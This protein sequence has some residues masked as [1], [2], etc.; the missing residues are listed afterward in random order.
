LLK[1]VKTNFYREGPRVSSLSPSL[2]DYLEAVY[3]LSRAEGSTR[4]G[5]VGGRL[6]V[7]KPSVN[8]AI[9]AL[10]AR[11]LL[12]HERYGGIRLSPRGLRAGAEIAGRHALLKDFFVSIL[13][14]DAPRAERD[15]C[16]AEHALSREALRRVGKLAVF[17]KTPGR[18]KILAEARSSLSGRKAR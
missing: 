11:G 1:L 7:S 8:A 5:L 13:A 17:L 6:K 4:A 16:R 12:E 18:R 14:M 3:G 9:K 2:E 10:A 15:A